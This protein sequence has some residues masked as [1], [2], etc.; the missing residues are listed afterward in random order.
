MGIALSHFFFHKIYDY[1][2]GKIKYDAHC[3]LLGMGKMLIPRLKY[4]LEQ[5]ATSASEIL[6]PTSQVRDRRMEFQLEKRLMRSLLPLSWWVE[7]GSTYGAYA[8][9]DTDFSVAT[10]VH[11][12]K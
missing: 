4:Y 12:K 8:T 2:R 3:P 6:S 7:K 5:S 10:M 1:K 11:V 9:T